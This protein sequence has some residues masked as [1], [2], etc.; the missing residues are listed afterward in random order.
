ML[1]FALP[2]LLLG[3]ACATTASVPV[4]NDAS[5]RVEKTLAGLTPGEPRRCLR[6]DDYTEMRTAKGVI[7]FVAGKNRVWRNDVVGAGCRGLERGDI[8]VIQS[9]SGR[10]CD[11]DLVQTRAA[12]GGMLSGSCSLGTFTP[13]SRK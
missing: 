13:Y 7:V 3:A 11:G 6:R 1:R 9:I 2:V 5:A 12:T 4:P 10:Q 8:V